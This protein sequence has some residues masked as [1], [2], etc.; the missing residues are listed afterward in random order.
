MTTKH[1]LPADGLRQVFDASRAP[2]Q[3]LRN[4]GWLLNWLGFTRR[5]STWLES[6][7][8]KTDLLGRGFFL[9]GD[10][11]TESVSRLELAPESS[12]ET[13]AQHTIRRASAQNPRATQRGTRVD[14]N[15]GENLRRRNLPAVP[16]P[17]HLVAPEVA[18]NSGTERQSQHRAHYAQQ[19]NHESTTSHI[20]DPT[21]QYATT[22]S[23]HARISQTTVT[24]ALLRR[25]A[26]GIDDNTITDTATMTPRTS[27]ANPRR[28]EIKHQLNALKEYGS[29]PLAGAVPEASDP[30]TVGEQWLS[31]VARRGCLTMQLPGKPLGEDS[32]ELVAS[33]VRQLHLDLDGPKTSR[34]QLIYYSIR[35]KVS[36]SRQGQTNKT[37]TQPKSA[38]NNNATGQHG[39]ASTQHTQRHD[40]TQ[41][42]DQRAWN[43]ND[44]KNMQHGFAEN[45]QQ[46]MKPHVSHSMPSP[47]S[48]STPQP[49]TQQQVLAD[50]MGRASDS[51]AD[52]MASTIVPSTSLPHARE[53]KDD[54]EYAATTIPDL[55][56]TRDVSAETAAIGTANHNM[57]LTPAATLKQSPQD[58]AER[59]KRILDDEARRHG[60][61]V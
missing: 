7:L 8:K 20:T 36:D 33:L 27:T 12:G 37:G 32:N 31:Y 51:L 42:G 10:A 6:L 30:A 17:R 16:S 40:A 45:H 11:L 47:F 60:I 5:E 49:K 15:L 28:L 2:A 18:L 54:A 19:I 1:I 46:P 58:L 4:R 53:P 29:H 9:W 24:T 13:A 22:P 56:H 61:D 48:Q 59:I 21:R 34:Q 39:Q 3:W 38:I 44:I 26:G 41:L 57:R 55:Q 14:G 52:A 50:L 35:T 23:S 43:S 25:L